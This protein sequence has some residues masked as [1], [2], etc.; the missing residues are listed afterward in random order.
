[1][2]QRSTDTLIASLTDEN[3]P[4]CKIPSPCLQT[5]WWLAVISLLSGIFMFYA[6]IRADIATQITQSY[7]QTEL[8]LSAAITIT[9]IYAT[10]CLSFPDCYGKPYAKYL[11]LLPFIALLLLNSITAANNT[12]TMQHMSEAFMNHKGIDCA[13]DI[14]LL[15]TIPAICVFLFIRKAASVHLY[16]SGFTALLGLSSAAYFILRIVEQN[17]DI[18]H[19][20]TWHMLPLIALSIAG[21]ILGK[22]LLRW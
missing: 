17:D 8:V 2:T 9:A 22:W 14:A 13:I 4:V 5:G 20:L 16:W 11:P 10:S 7:F 15:S 12:D 1:M 3:T 19:L 21:A 6:G 18:W